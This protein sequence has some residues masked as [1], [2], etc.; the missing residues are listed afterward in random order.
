MRCGR[1]AAS[2]TV[3]IPALVNNAHSNA[4]TIATATRS[5]RAAET[6]KVIEETVA[7][8]AAEGPTEAELQAAKKYVIGAYPINNLDNSGAIARTLVELQIDDLGIDY[9]QRRAD[10]INAVTIEQ[11]KAIAKKLLTVKPA[12][13]IL[14][15]ATAGQRR[16]KQTAS[17]QSKK[18]TKGSP[19]FAVA[20][21]GGGARGLAHI[22]VIEALDELGIRPVA[23]SG[24]SIGAI[25]G[26]GMAAGM[27]GRD[28]HALRAL[29]VHQS[30]GACGAHVACP[31]GDAGRD[32]GA[33]PNS[34]AVQYRAHSGGVPAGG[35]TCMISRTSASPCR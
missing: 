32:D 12:V 26:A 11:V 35:D 13:M 18:A 25:M 30:R 15:P 17:A 1:S 31:T 34:G 7:R 20:F 10:I 6:L 28:I 5:D 19:T 33:R 2:S 9:M 16:V 24:S 3:S 21:G 27:A 14:G 4:L 8:M 22:H 29:G 23:I